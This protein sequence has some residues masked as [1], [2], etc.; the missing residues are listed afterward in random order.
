MKT[1]A[2]PSPK[3]HRQRQSYLLLTDGLPQFPVSP[4]RWQS[5][6]S[7]PLYSYIDQ[8]SRILTWLHSH[9]DL[10]QN[11]KRGV[12][13]RISAQPDVIRTPSYPHSLADSTSEYAHSAK[14][15]ENRKGLDT[16]KESSRNNSYP[17]SGSALAEHLLY[18]MNTPSP[19]PQKQGT[20]KTQVSEVS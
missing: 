18:K 16:Y 4:G 5:S 13:R 11:Y 10:P 19:S 8:D 6:S 15:T 9:P 20:Q 1:S 7:E 12:K 3:T 17:V 14:T 2:I